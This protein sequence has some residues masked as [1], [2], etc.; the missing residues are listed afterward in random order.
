MLWLAPTAYARIS[1]LTVQIWLAII[2]GFPIFSKW[3]CTVWKNSRSL[4][5]NNKD[6]TLCI[7]DLFDWKRQKNLNW[8]T[9]NF[10]IRSLWYWAV[11]PGG[12]A[13]CQYIPHIMGGPRLSDLTWCQTGHWSPG[14]ERMRDEI[15][16]NTILHY[17]N[18]IFSCM[19]VNFTFSLRLRF[20]MVPPSDASPISVK[21]LALS[22]D[23]I[24]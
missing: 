23:I 14:W 1:L 2:C 7:S 21:L 19:R 4:S 3:M 11:C 20:S 17:G 12:Q 10:G 16:K 13:V 9:C 15:V 24:L 22:V 5:G 6:P 8:L 18:D